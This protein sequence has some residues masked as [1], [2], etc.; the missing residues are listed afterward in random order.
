MRARKLGVTPLPEQ[1]VKIDQLKS[2]IGRIERAE[3]SI[4]PQQV[5]R[6]AAVLDRSGAPQSGDPLPPLWHWIFFTTGIRQSELAPDGHAARGEFLPPVFLPR[7][8]WAGGRLRFHS[9]IQIGDHIARHSEIRSIDEKLGRSGRL[10]FVTVGHK[11]SA[12]NGTLLLS[13]EQDIVYRDHPL[14]DAAPPKR[15]EAP[16]Q[17]EWRREVHPSACLLFRYSALTFNGHRIHYDLP[18]AREEGYA[19]LVVHGPLLATLLLELLSDAELSRRVKSFSY[20]AVAP[21]F[22]T[23]PF[24][25]CGRRE[26]D[27]STVRLWVQTQDG[28]LAMSAAAELA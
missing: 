10:I 8:M 14:P 1:N 11:F 15:V 27:G 22:D 18:Y 7:R 16:A 19:G 20:R 12:D 28:A 5:Q 23:A 6:L 25:V 13:E 9:A 17:P 4:T 2:W 21:L 26:E 24:T 3:D